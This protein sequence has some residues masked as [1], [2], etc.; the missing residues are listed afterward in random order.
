MN[1]NLELPVQDVRDACAEEIGHMKEKVFKVVKKKEC[2]E[3]I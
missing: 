2:Y 1:E 3:K